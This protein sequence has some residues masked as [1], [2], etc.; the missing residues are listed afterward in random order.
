[1]TFAPAPKPTED[2]DDSTHKRDRKGRRVPRTRLRR[3][4]LSDRLKVDVF[5][6][7]RG[8]WEVRRYLNRVR[9]AR[10]LTLKQLAQLV[11][12]PPCLVWRLLYSSK[13][14]KGPKLETLDDYAKALG[15]AVILVPVDARGKTDPHCA[16]RIKALESAQPAAPR[17]AK[18]AP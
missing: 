3:F 14:P 18:G 9:K 1:M 15:L 6:V 13:N 2:L 11:G 10:G 5:N 7:G 8:G 12:R 4:D 16:A 17:K